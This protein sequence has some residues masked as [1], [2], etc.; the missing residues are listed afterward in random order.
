MIHFKGNKRER[1]GTGR[2]ARRHCLTGG[3]FPHQ[4]KELMR[5]RFPCHPPQ[6]LSER[7]RRQPLVLHVGVNQIN[8]TLDIGYRRRERQTPL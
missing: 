8:G 2:G 5:P 3:A 6:Y 1:M 7:V 4:A